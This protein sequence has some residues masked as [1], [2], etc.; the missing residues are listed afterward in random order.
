M[1]KYLHGLI[2]WWPSIWMKEAKLVQLKSSSIVLLEV[3]GAPTSG[4]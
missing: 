1:K 3:L 4:P 2:I